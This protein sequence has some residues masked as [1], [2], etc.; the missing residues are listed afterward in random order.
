MSARYAFRLPLL[1]LALALG[2]CAVTGGE[3]GTPREAGTNL[4]G[5]ACTV[6]AGPATLGAGGERQTTVHCGSWQQPSARIA[7]R[8][9]TQP[10]TGDSPAAA[11]A[12]GP[13][14]A[15][16]DSRMRCDAPAATAFA[17]GLDGAVM[18][19]R[20]LNGGFPMVALALAAEG[21]IFLA[22][23]I[24]AAL[25]VVER[26]VLA[27]LGRGTLGAETAESRAIAFVRAATGRPLAGAGALDAYYTALAT[28]QYQDTVQDFAASEENYR[29]ALLVQAEAIGSDDPS[30]ADPLMHVALELSNQGRYDEAAPLFDEAQRLAA[31]SINPSDLPRLLSYRAIDAANQNRLD[32]ALGFAAK[33]TALRREFAARNGNEVGNGFTGFAGGGDLISYGGASGT[34]I[35][36]DLAQS[37][38]TEAAL[39][40]RLNRLDEAA[41]KADEAIAIT[42][43][44]RAA[45][46]WWL[47]QFLETRATVAAAGGDSRSAAALQGDAV[48]IWAN[49]LPDS[50]PEGLARL[51]LGRYQHA[52]GRSDAAIATYRQGLATL[53]ARNAE[54]RP[55][56]LI[57]FL[58]VASAAA[59]ATP[60]EAGRLE[61]EMFEA[62][63]LMRSGVTSRTVS[64]ATARLAAGDQQ[65]GGVIRAQQEN[66][67][68]RYALVAA[69]NRALAVPAEVR[70][71][72]AIDGLRS[73]LIE[74]EAE[75]RRLDETLQAASSG[76]RQLLA[77]PVGA[78]ELQALLKPGEAV[79]AFASAETATYGFL[80]RADRLRIWRIDA[81]DQAIGDVVIA[82]RKGV[83][84]TRSGLPRF[85]VE[86]SRGLYRTLFDPVAGDLDGVTSLVTSAN[87]ALASIPFGILVAGP[88]E[89]RGGSYREVDWLVRHYAL[90]QVPSVR[91][92]ADLRRVG[93]AS[94]GTQALVGFGDYQPPRDMN[95]LFSSLPANCVRDRKVLGALGPL[96]GTAVELERVAAQ[97]GAGPDALVLGDAFTK[98]AVTGRPLSDYRIVYFATHAVLASEI[99]CFAEPALLVSP[100]P[101]AGAD[102]ALLKLSDIL[103]LKLDADLVVLSACNTGGT[104]GKSGGE[105]LSGLT[106]A[107]FYAGA[108]RL[109]ASHWPVPDASTAA[110]MTAIFG[111]QGVGG[112]G[113]LR[114]AQ[115][116][117]IDGR[118]PG[119]TPVEWSHPLFWA[120][121]STIGD[122]TGVAAR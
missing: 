39:L 7:E 77:T 15:E 5:E 9:A 28:A 112:A 99:R 107:F 30:S 51:A 71:T 110:L 58:D 14:R 122:G 119:T 69:L 83:T 96:P 2:A 105:A 76:Y 114:D 111:G 116:G 46:P 49:T 94:G 40:L 92:F 35:G 48:T 29:K 63:Q 68:K 53:K 50:V 106:R 101:A 90:A 11:L 56:E 64:L 95:A 115:L 19:C 36:I 100:G 3:T 45:P 91:A 82:L 78:S 52:T 70:D 85:P 103:N 62:M 25:P 59:A 75:G 22:D 16:L 60:G 65:V 79:V 12:A 66:D 93:T 98:T 81:G 1:A 20:L 6:T 10:Q 38:H 113:A 97:L 23:G 104:D 118:G 18:Q 108:R 13:W 27:A 117:L 43:A 42:R 86:Q 31:A 109:I 17:G 84:P 87:G 57:G 34:V 37:L 33:A 89:A 44:S 47:P 4:V 102:S 61:V 26:A 80:V 120:G 73:R 88:G 55:R 32:D 41:Q 67:R 72:K 74:T 54:I 121:F 21:R 24:P 8:G